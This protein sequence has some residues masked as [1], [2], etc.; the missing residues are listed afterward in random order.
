[1]IV[2]GYLFLAL[3]LLASSVGGIWL[4]YVAIKQQKYLW[5]VLMLLVPFS[6]LVFVALNWADTKKPFFVSLASIPLVLAGF[7]LGV[8]G[9]M[10]QAGL[11]LAAEPRSR[12]LM[13]AA[14]QA[15]PG[16]APEPVPAPVPVAPQPPAPLAAAPRTPRAPVARPVEPRPLPAPPPA[17]APAD[18][19]VEPVRS[20]PPVTHPA[21]AAPSAPQGAAAVRV[22]F[23]KIESEPGEVLRSVRLRIANPA[24]RAITKVSVYLG[25]VDRTGRPLKSWTTEHSDPDKPELVAANATREFSC[26]AFFMPDTTSVVRVV[27]RSVTFSDGAEWTPQ[28]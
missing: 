21:P 7:L 19:A 20:E 5:F 11:E 24:N 26:P 4:L 27:L 14:Q 28:Q 25:Y 6:P 1:M 3:G 15:T 16:P 12:R 2:L 13:E 22:E 18:R 9:A 23:V 8:R 17:P 10:D